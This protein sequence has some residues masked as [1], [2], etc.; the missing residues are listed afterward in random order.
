MKSF[1]DAF[2]LTVANPATAEWTPPSKARLA[3]EDAKAKGG[4][5]KKT[6][7]PAKK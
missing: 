3:A 6:A 5:K 2:P 4:R 7:D 1:D